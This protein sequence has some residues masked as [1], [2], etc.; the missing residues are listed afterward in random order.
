MSTIRHFILFVGCWLAISWAKGQHAPKREFRAVWVTTLANLDWPQ[1]PGMNMERQQQEFVDLLDLL[2]RSGFNAV[3]VQVRPAGD[4]FYPSDIAIW[5]HYLTGAQGRAPQYD[6][7]QFMIDETHKRNMEFHAWFNPL[8]AVSHI[9]KVPVSVNHISKEKPHWCFDYGVTRYLNP[10]LPAVREYVTEVVGE[11]VRNYDIDGV[12]FDDYFYPYPIAGQPIPDW[13]TYK[14]FGDGFSSISEWRRFNIDRIIQMTSEEIK[15]TKP[16]VKF[17][18]SPFGVWRNKER[19][20]DGSDTYRACASFD[21]LYADSRKWYLRGWVDY[22][23]PQLYWT[24]RDYRA[25][26]RELL[27]WWADMETDRHLYVGHAVSRLRD[28]PKPKN[29]TPAEFALQIQLIREN[30]RGEGSIFFRAGNLRDNLDGITNMLRDRVYN[31]PALVPAMPWLDSIP[32]GRPNNLNGFFEG[33]GVYLSWEAPKAETALDS[34]QYYVVYRFDAFD[35]VRDMDNPENIVSITRKPSLWDDSIVPG[36][37]YVYCVT[38][39]DRLHNESLRFIHREISCIPE[40]KTATT[41]P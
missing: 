24:T 10:G 15:R 25:N 30:N 8:R 17:G 11:V 35:D 26:Y 7:L 34:A 37:T 5:S 14:T 3:V 12:H 13:E 28:N 38:A 18:I 29:F 4:A 31:Q 27:E 36:L 33:E 6:P 1:Q 23:A 39:V 19:D 2:E 16:W 22:I 9:E 40:E 21:D 20:E 41:G 32:P